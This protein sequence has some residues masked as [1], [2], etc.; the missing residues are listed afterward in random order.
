MEAV[1]NDKHT[2]THERI[3]QELK[4]VDTTAPAREMVN[5]LA[6]NVCGPLQS[7]DI[8]VVGAPMDLEYPLTPSIPPHFESR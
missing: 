4:E 2:Q 6:T 5:P 7:V 1:A 3:L 8:E